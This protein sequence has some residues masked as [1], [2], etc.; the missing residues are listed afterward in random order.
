MN[1]FYSDIKSE[2]SKNHFTSCP[3]ILLKLSKFP[4]F[5]KFECFKS[6]A[7]RKQILHKW[8]GEGGTGSQ[9]L[10]TTRTT[11]LNRVNGSNGFLISWFL[12]ENLH[13]FY[14]LKTLKVLFKNS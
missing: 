1:V 11:S 13:A 6:L 12:K 8:G 7:T 9:P 4:G 3:S 5:L 2:S 14:G 10:R